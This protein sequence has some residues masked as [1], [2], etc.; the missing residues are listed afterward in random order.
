M[1]VNN[2]IDA[3]VVLQIRS[4]LDKLHKDGQH[5]VRGV[6]SDDWRKLRY[7]TARGRARG[8][9]K[10]TGPSVT[11][12][13]DE[14]GVISSYISKAASSQTGALHNYFIVKPDNGCLA[15]SGLALVRPV[16]KLNFDSE[17][18]LNFH[19]WFHCL[20]GASVDDHLMIGWRLEAPE[21]KGTSHDY[22][23]AQPLRRF[24]VAERAYGMHERFSERFPTIP[25]PA[26][27]A[28]ELCL[29]AVLIACGKDALREF[30]RG[31]NNEQVRVAAK[32]L[33][34]KIFVMGVSVPSAP[35]V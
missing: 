19:V 29:N 28:V 21:G 26:S 16:L 4:I 18:K 31:S 30:I 22:Y 9:V 34:S 3:D 25:L 23:H 2:C 17:P 20:P 13:I 15:E 35:A 27:S 11:D 8:V 14:A 7:I 10:V 12:I 24:G 33:W 32:A 5:W 6:A 1:I